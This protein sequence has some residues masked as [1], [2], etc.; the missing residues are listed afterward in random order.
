MSPPIPRRR[1]AWPVSDSP[2]P[3]FAL[4]SSAIWKSPKIVPRV[5]DRVA[6]LTL[7]SGAIAISKLATGRPL[8]AQGG[9][10]AVDQS[11][12]RRR[13]PTRLHGSQCTK[14]GIGVAKQLQRLS[15]LQA[16]GDRVRLL[17]EEPPQQQGGLTPAF[18]PDRRI[19]AWRKRASLRMFESG[20]R[21]NRSRTLSASRTLPARTICSARSSTCPPLARIV[22]VCV[23]GALAPGAELAAKANP[24]AKTPNA[25]TTGP[26]SVT[27]L[28]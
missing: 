18:Q 10:I 4:P 15:Q 22:R 23:V 7:L 16:G 26:P 24:A 27:S 21:A 1:N 28:R 9:G 12:D 5:S 19:L 14:R 3:D 2:V 8:G 25:A 13:Q 20:S 17:V 11:G 6:R